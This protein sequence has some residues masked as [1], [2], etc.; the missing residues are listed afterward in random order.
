MKRRKL[1]LRITLYI[2]TGYAVWLFIMYFCQDKVIFPAD[3]APRP[4][5]PPSEVELLKI[6]TDDG[7]VEGWLIP[8]KTKPAQGSPLLVYFHGNGEI[9]NQ[10]E[11]NIEG[12]S[13]LGFCVLLPEYRGYGNSAGEPSQEA[14]VSDALAFLEIATAHPGVDPERILYHGRS[15]GGAIAAQ[16]AIKRPP[17]A[18]ILESTPSNVSKMALKFG[19]PP[20]L[21]RSPFRTDE[22]VEK[23]Q[24][25]MLIMHGTQDNIVPMRHGMKLAKIAGERGKLVTFDCGHNDMPGMGNARTYWDEI[26]SFAEKA[27]L[28][29]N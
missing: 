2:L 27:G 28:V 6:E 11:W 8:A 9:I 22:A 21:L 16:V 20:F 15:L 4:S 10:Q 5:P 25:P 14:I 12:Y 19:M 17:K 18:V 1:Y 29:Q 24:S 13:D 26:G 23:I 7:I 3:L